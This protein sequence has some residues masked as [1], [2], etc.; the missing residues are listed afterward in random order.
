MKH[1]DVRTADEIICDMLA[2]DKSFEEIAKRLLRTE[3][4]VESRFKVICAKLGPQA[5]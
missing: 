2:D 4:W 5:Q 3:Q 1:Q